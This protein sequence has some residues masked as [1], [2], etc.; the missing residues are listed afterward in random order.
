MI[1]PALEDALVHPRLFS[2]SHCP[3][4]VEKIHALAMGRTVMREAMVAVVNFI[5][6]VGSLKSGLNKIV[7][8]MEDL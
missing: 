4:V 5:L 3:A 7:V 8:K 1:A 2:P 6:M